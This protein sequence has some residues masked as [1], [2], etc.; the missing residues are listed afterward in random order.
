MLDYSLRDS[1]LVIAIYATICIVWA[2]FA[3]WVPPTIIEATYIPVTIPNLPIE[4]HLIAAAVPLAV[5]LH[6]VIVLLIRAIDRKKPGILVQSTR[7]DSHV[8]VVLTVFSAA[9]LALTVLSG[10][11]GDYGGYLKEWIGVLE[12]RDPWNY[13]DTINPNAYG[14]LFNVLAPMAWVNLLANKLLFA[15]S[16]LVYIIWLIKDIAPRQGFVALSW[17]SMGLWLFNP[18]PWWQIA[19]LGHFDIL[20]GLTC[21]AAVHCRVRN[22]DWLSGTWLAVGTLLK[23]MPFVILPFLAFNGRRVH[24]RLIISCIGVVVSG[25]IVSVLV[26]GT[27]TFKPL[28]FAAT[29]EAIESIYV[30]LDPTHSPLSL[31]GGAQWLNSQRLAEP[32]LLLA[33]LGVYAW[34]VLRRTDPA[35][36]AALAVLVTLLFYWVGWA[37]Y[38]MVFFV[39]ILY[40][41]VSE[42]E[43]SNRSLVLIAL[44][45]GYFS[46]LAVSDLVGSIV[47]Y[48]IFSRTNMVM[49]LLRFLGGCALVV[50]LSA[51]SSYERILRPSP[52]SQDIVR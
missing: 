9:F 34:C 52:R 5:V 37:Q 15:I 39:L 35:L 22:K 33:G 47:G 18:L 13:V 16:Y 50:A 42:W 29:R 19:Y 17:P 49:I 51:V 40:W 25:L 30:F 31:F 48:D 6:L 4:Y 14:P 3:Y 36:S 12:G 8:N 7:S 2:E 45:G 27:S 41:V 43:R 44:L 20:V 38:Q 32:M 10:V 24:F 1:L 11:Q 26:W 23:F 28:K 46:F 21:V